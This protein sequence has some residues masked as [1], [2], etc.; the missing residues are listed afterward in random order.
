[1]DPNSGKKDMFNKSSREEGLKALAL[2][3]DFFL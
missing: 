2:E 3:D 1:M